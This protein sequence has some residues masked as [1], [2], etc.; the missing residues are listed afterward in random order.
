MILTPHLLVGAAIGSKVHSW[1]AVIILSIA[2]HYILDAIPHFEYR[3]RFLKNKTFNRDL[4]VDSLKLGADFAVGFFTV[5]YLGANSINFQ[6][7]ALGMAAAV[8]P[9]FLQFLYFMTKTEVGAF[10]QKIH[11]YFHFDKKNLY[12]WHGV[13]TIIVTITSVFTL[14]IK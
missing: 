3:V 12:A 5:F 2:S 1:W 6:N 11:S 7:M 8:L 13:F 4:A 14:L 9:D 10:F